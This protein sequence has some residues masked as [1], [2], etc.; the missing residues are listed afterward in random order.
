MLIAVPNGNEYAISMGKA[1]FAIMILVCNWLK[2]FLRN[3]NSSTQNSIH[4]ATT[5]RNTEDVFA[6]LERRS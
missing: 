4:L 1:H 2:E 5:G 3:Q 6:D